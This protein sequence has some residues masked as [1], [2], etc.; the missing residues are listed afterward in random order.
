MAATVSLIPQSFR[1]S[2]A[3]YGGGLVDVLRPGEVPTVLR[4]GKG[5]FTREQMAALSSTPEIRIEFVNQGCHNSRWRWCGGD[6]RCF[7]IRVVTDG[8]QQGGPFCVAL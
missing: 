7:I 6:G 2:G 3:Y 8:I 5:E 1:V 4:R